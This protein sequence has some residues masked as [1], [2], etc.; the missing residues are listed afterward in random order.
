MVN[1][2]YRNQHNQIHGGEIKAMSVLEWYERLPENMKQNVKTIDL[3]TIKQVPERL[4][5]FEV[6]RRKADWERFYLPQKGLTG[7]RDSRGRF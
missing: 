4:P 1:R 2:Y 3:S 6:N 7:K 5:E